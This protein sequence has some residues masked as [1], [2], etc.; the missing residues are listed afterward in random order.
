[1]IKSNDFSYPEYF[2]HLHYLLSIF[3]YPL[4]I[5]LIPGCYPPP[6][7]SFPSSSSQSFSVQGSTVSR[8]LHPTQGKDK[9][10]LLFVSIL[11][12]LAA[13]YILG[14]ENLKLCCLPKIFQTGGASRKAVGVPL[15]ASTSPTSTTWQRDKCQVH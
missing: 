1:M 6:G 15:G 10:Y 9:L 5:I 14:F 12:I 13:M 4:S 8:K 3:H 11:I 2:I 7:H